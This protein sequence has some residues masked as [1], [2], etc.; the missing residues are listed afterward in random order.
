MVG[1]DA[2]GVTETGIG[3]VEA[4]LLGLN[5]GGAVVAGTDCSPLDTLAGVGSSGT[6]RSD[7]NDFFTPLR[8]TPLHHRFAAPIFV[9]MKRTG[10][11]VLYVLGGFL[12]LL[13]IAMWAAPG[14]L[15]RYIEKNDLDLI[16]RE[17]FIGDLRIGWFTGK[18]RVEGFEMR[19]QDSSQVFMRIDALETKLS[20]G[21]LFKKR[22]HLPYLHVHRLD[23]QVAQAGTS[24][25]FDDLAQ[26][27]ADPQAPEASESEW[28]FALEDFALLRSAIHYQSDLHP[29]VEI[30]SLEVRIPLITDQMEAMDVYAQLDLLSGGQLST[31]V[32][33][34]LAGETYAID[35]RAQDAALSLVEP[36]FATAIQLDRVEGTAQSDLHLFG[37]WADTDLLNVSGSFGL[38]GLHLIDPHGEPLVSCED[39]DLVIDTVRMKE[40]LYTLDHLYI[41]GF[42]SIFELYDEGDNF[43]NL[44]V[45]DTSTTPTD[46]LG[47]EGVEID[48]SN[49]FAVLAYYIEDI[50][51]SYKESVYNLRELDIAE[52]AFQF[53]DYTLTDPFRY[54]LTGL[55]IHGD[56]LYSEKASITAT[57]GAVL[58]NAGTFEG[59]FTA[60]TDNLANMDIAY[61]I[62]GAGLTPFAPYTSHYVAHPI[63]R[64]DVLYEC[65]TT[66]RDGIIDS[67]NVMVFEEFT[68]GSRTEAKALYDLPVRL[69]IN[70]LKDLNGEIH[71]DVPIEGD[72]KDPNYKL[73]KVIWQTVRN[74]L[75]RAVT[76]PYRLLARTF[77]ID[78]DGLKQL[79]F[80]LLQREVNKEHERQLRDLGKVLKAK[81]DLNV[82][83]KRVTDK[84]E[85]VERYAITEAKRRY[86]YGEDQ[87]EEH[88][89][90]RDQRRALQDYDIKDSLFV[91]WLD[92]R[93]PAAAL[94]EPVQRKCLLYIGEESA[95]AA[96]D[97]IGTRR[98]QSI[99][100][101]LV[102]G[103]GLDPARF[104]FTIVPDDSLITSRSTAIY[105]IGFWMEDL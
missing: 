85:E 81:D 76:A 45:T 95:I 94:R 70:L 99:L 44:L 66:I 56:S 18:V 68:F 12:L 87:T 17:V 13:A 54:S 35:F 101:Q 71:L 16:G 36:F 28:T 30:D 89:L 50:A 58:N 3:C 74:I 91:Q 93:L 60:Y 57:A 15:I 41:R 64:G 42:Y 47:V 11:W 9:V 20:M 25:N 75:L 100:N 14:Y 43:S 5:E 97:R 21:G 88:T 90:D 84:F 51:K 77:S 69:A 83:F 8:H 19:E 104:R 73:G 7:L 80:G 48:Y 67:K 82:E 32:H 40:G 96:V 59:R 52:S 53:N 2:K 37:S 10:R 46:S 65:E 72:L 34:D 86:L 33:L 4:K 79:H 23:V 1:A 63:T 24:F 61:A 27:E 39:F 6:P 31:D 103:E 38:N 62:R 98:S 78:E 92:E 22:I 49:P 29:G 26:Q 102:E 105:N 55:H